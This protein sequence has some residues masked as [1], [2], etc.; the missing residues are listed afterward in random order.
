MRIP[1]TIGDKGG[2]GY[3]VL[4]LR[5]KT[6]VNGQDSHLGSPQ[7]PHR[8]LAVEEKGSTADPSLL[9]NRTHETMCSDV[10]SKKSFEG[11]HLHEHA[12]Q[13]G[14]EDPTLTFKENNAKQTSVNTAM[15]IDHILWRNQKRSHNKIYEAFSSIT[16]A[17]A[18]YFVS[19]LFPVTLHNPVRNRKQ[20]FLKNNSVEFNLSAINRIPQAHWFQLPQF[21]SPESGR[22]W[23][24]QPVIGSDGLQLFAHRP[25]PH[26][27]PIREMMQ[28]DQPEEQ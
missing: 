13:S 27:L 16:D 10:T 2:L 18:I 12:V 15:F 26:T 28:C 14:R 25:P 4:T 17:P 6:Y 19:D 21:Q 5:Q 20:A 22:V 1:S 8:I 3:S 9:A 23:D 24:I 7:P 11:C